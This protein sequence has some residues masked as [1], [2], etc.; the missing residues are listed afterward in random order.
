MLFRVLLAVSPH[1]STLPP[2]PQETIRHALI[3][4]GRPF[5]GPPDARP[6]ASLITMVFHQFDPSSLDYMLG[7]LY[8]SDSLY[9]IFGSFTI[10]GPAI[11]PTI[12]SAI[13]PKKSGPDG[14][15]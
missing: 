3:R 14:W 4:Y 1:L 5:A 12:P 2:F 13:G 6:G 11:E 8:F 10:G 15:H 7:R 9:F